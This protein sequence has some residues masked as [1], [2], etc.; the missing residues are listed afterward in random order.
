MS[1]PWY[2]TLQFYGASLVDAL[3]AI[4]PGTSASGKA[5]VLDADG[6]I[7]GVTFAAGLKSATVTLTNAQI[8]ALPTTG[9]TVVAAQGAHLM[10]Q[11]V[12]IACLVD[13]TAGAYTNIDALAALDLE[14]GAV[15][16]SGTLPITTPFGSAGITPAIIQTME[17]SSNSLAGAGLANAALTV[18]VNNEGDGPLTGGHDSNSLIVTVAYLVVNTLTGALV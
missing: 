9:I 6:K 1:V 13:T 3:S 10:I 2:E 12:T 14:M 8:K 11:P 17:A 4:T 7:D 5:L 18:N 16:Y 15:L